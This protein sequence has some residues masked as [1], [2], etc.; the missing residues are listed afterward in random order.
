MQIDH[1]R[2]RAGRAARLGDG[3]DDGGQRAAVIGMF[4]WVSSSEKSSTNRR[5]S[6]VSFE[7]DKFCIS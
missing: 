6:A 3:G 5:C 7:F 2:R 4:H 1:G